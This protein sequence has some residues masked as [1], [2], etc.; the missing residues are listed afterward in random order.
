VFACEVSPHWRR[1]GLFSVCQCRWQEQLPT[2][3]CSKY[4][5]LAG[6]LAGTRQDIPHATSSTPLPKTVNLP[7]NIMSKQAEADATEKTERF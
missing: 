4:W 1:R 7:A 5:V 3:G 6:K 2:A